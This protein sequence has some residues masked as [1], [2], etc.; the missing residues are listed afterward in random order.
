MLGRYRLGEV[1]G[2]GGGGVVHR[3]Y[4]P[5]LDREVAVKLMLLEHRLGPDHPDLAPPLNS[6]GVSAARR[7]RGEEALAHHTRAL[8]IRQA[9][10][11]PDHPAVAAS[12]SNLAWAELELGRF[13]AAI[14]S[15]SAALVALEARLGPEHPELTYTL[16]YTLTGLAMT[17]VEAGRP[18]EAID[19]LERALAIGENA[20][21]RALFVGETEF[22]LARALVDAG[23][24][25][26]RALALARSAHER[27]MQAD[28][29]EAAAEVEAWL[30]TRL[31]SSPRD[32]HGSD[33]SGRTGK[34]EGTPDPG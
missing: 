34:P 18:L 17:F 7:G 32:P 23:R 3:A 29:P 9:A 12:R 13:E 15:F 6:L 24:E 1:L 11:P 33:G 19:P 2:R 20:E 30:T 26:K 28:D 10:F 22:T 8:A 5:R 14:E 25:R 16:T 21:T 4:D 27:W 31:A